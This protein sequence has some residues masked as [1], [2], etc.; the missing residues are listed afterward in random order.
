LLGT[1]PS[2]LGVDN[3]DVINALQRTIKRN[4]QKPTEGSGE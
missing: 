2:N 3:Q 1:V 4:V